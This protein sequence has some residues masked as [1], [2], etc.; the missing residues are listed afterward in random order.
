MRRRRWWALLVP[1]TWGLDDLK[2]W[3]MHSPY[4]CIRDVMSHWQCLEAHEHLQLS[5]RQDELDAYANKD[6]GS[7]PRQLRPQDIANTLLHSY[8]VALQAC[9]C[10]CRSSAFSQRS[11]EDKGLRGYYVTDGM[12]RQRYLH[13]REAAHLLG[14]ADI[15]VYGPERGFSEGGG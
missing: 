12:G 3:P 15:T 9:P 14:I 6:Y 10:G 4:R 1:D 7:D 11:L 5:L 8:S 13:P 2:P